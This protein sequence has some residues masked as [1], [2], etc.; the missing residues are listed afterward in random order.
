VWEVLAVRTTSGRRDAA[1]TAFR[2][3]PALT[4]DSMGKL[5][6]ATLEQAVALAGPYRDERLR[7]LASG[8]DVFKRNRDLPEQLRSGIDRA[9]KALA[10][11]PHLTTVSGDRLLLFA[12]GHPVFPNDA[13]LIRVLARLQSDRDS[14]ADQL[15]GV[16]TGVQRAALYLTHHGSVTC[17]EADPLCRICPLRLTCPFHQGAAA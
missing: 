2:R 12:G 4:P 14:A 11:L 3:I 16:L 5:P 17:L 1:M 8:V 13:D 6:R 9:R 7:A 10:L 15:G